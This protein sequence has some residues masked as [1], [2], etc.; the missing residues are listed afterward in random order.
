MSRRTRRHAA[1]LALRRLTDEHENI[2]VDTGSPVPF[3]FRPKRTKPNKKR[4][5][6]GPSKKNSPNTPV[7]TKPRPTFQCLDSDSSDNEVSNDLKNEFMK[8]IKS[9]VNNFF[10]AA[11]CSDDEDDIIHVPIVTTTIKLPLVVDD[12]IHVPL[13]DNLVYK[14]TVEDVDAIHVPKD[15][16]AT[17][18]TVPTKSL[19]VLSD[20]DDDCGV[21]SAPNISDQIEEV[22][23]EGEN[24]P[25]PKA[26]EEQELMDIV[27]NILD[28]DTVEVDTSTTEPDNW[29][30]LQNKVNEVMDSI[31]SIISTI[32][33][34]KEKPKEEKSPVKSKPTC[35]VCL[36]VLGDE[37]VAG[38][39][40]CGH[41]FCMTCIKE[42][43]KT[44]KKCPTCRKNITLKKIH[45][46]YL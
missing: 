39:T 8:N 4:K 45:Q 27:H 5:S 40:L 24:N 22:S 29:N 11:N 6:T 10:K 37:V 41:I 34:V 31:N 12:D 17:K 32:D 2:D 36:E 23:L 16:T 44:S 14:P 13:D 19:Y 33:E 46:L 30:K 38:A 7:S 9:Q 25:D 42:V 21:V 20:S 35:P 43:A 26:I 28:T 3:S 15:T 1:V 18:P